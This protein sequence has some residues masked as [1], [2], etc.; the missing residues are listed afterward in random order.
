M[1]WGNINWGLEAG[2]TVGVG[3]G[4]LFIYRHFQLRGVGKTSTAWPKIASCIVTSVITEKESWEGRTRYVDNIPTVEYTYDV[5]RKSYSGDNIAYKVF[6]SLTRPAAEKILE[7]Y[8]IGATVDVHYN[9]S[10][11]SQSV[12]EPSMQQPMTLLVLG[13]IFLPIG[14][15]MMMVGGLGG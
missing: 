6:S 14:L 4:I 11:P 10:N 5:D 12:L 9:P 13:L 2:G 7:K 8:P 1:N 15:L 3:V